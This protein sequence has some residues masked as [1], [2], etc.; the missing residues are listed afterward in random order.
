GARAHAAEVKAQDDDARAAQSPRQTVDYFV[1]HGAAV[2]RVRM[3]DHGGHPGRDVLGFF[4]QR[5]NPACGTGERERLDAARHGA[6]VRPVVGELQV[7]AE[8][9]VA[10]QLDGRLQGVAVLARHA[11]EIALYGGLHL[12]LAVLDF[13]D[14]LAGLFDGD[15]LLHGDLLLNRGPGGG[16]D[17]A[18]RQ[19]LQRDLA[20]DQLGLQGGPPG[21]DLEFGLAVE[22]DF[23]VLLLE[24]DAGIRVL[25]VEAL[26]DFFPRL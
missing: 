4:E 12:Q 2:Q 18:V 24:L 22:Q 19:A 14:E 5:F 13:L 15:S 1:V 23:G 8:I 6:S 20:F 10:E 17:L 3:A 11:H 26:V 16:N 25:E 7:D 21:L 9:V